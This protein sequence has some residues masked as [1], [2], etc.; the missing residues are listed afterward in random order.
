VK[1]I[2]GKLMESDASPAEIL[3]R[4]NT[5]LTLELAQQLIEEAKRTPSKT[6]I[7]ARCRVPYSTLKF[8]LKQGSEGD[9]RFEHF[10]A[11]FEAAKSIHEERY[12]ENVEEVARDDNP[13]A[14][15]ARLR[16]NQY[17]I[18]KYCATGSVGSVIENGADAY[19]LS[20]LPTDELRRFMQ[21]LKALKAH[22]DGADREEVERRLKKLEAQ[23]DGSE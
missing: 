17:M 12:L 20:V 19:D 11:E 13:R 16:A 3:A 21:T 22:N 2:K 6:L 9:P 14:A 23:S 5:S 4:A 10:T 8:W 1:L 15:N 7:A 18:E